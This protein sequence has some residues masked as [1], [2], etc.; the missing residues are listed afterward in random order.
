M[1]KFIMTL[2]NNKYHYAYKTIRLETGEYYY[3]IHSTNDLNDGYQ[4]SGNRI[5]YLLSKNEFLITGIIEFFNSRSDALLFERQL[6]TKET[7]NDPLC[8]NLVPGGAGTDI[9]YKTKEE[10]KK[11][12]SEMRKGVPASENRKAK[13]KQ[14]WTNKTPEERRAIALERA[15]NRVYTQEGLERIRESNRTRVYTEETKKKKSKP[16]SEETKQ[17]ISNS[18]KGFKISSEVKQKMSEAQK[19]RP[20]MTPE[21]RASFLYITPHG[22]FYSSNTA[23]KVCGCA[24]GNNIIRRCKSTLPKWNEYYIVKL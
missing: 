1:E 24:Q 11:K 12:L 15:K 9:I 23:A 14:F 21:Q 10:T 18:R 4:G 19:A 2:S 13:L 22:T 3:G 20:P 6:V 17:K 7:I 8:L 16:R 5:Q